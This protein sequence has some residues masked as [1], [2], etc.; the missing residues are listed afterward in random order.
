MQRQ[1]TLL[2]HA[3][4][5]FSGSAGTSKKRL[6][7]LQNQLPSF[8]PLGISLNFGQVAASWIVTQTTPT[9]TDAVCVE[10]HFVQG[11]T[12]MFMKRS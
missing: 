9:C 3:G 7:D 2:S 10:P 1:N 5:P 6:H 4:T 12:S 11:G 8:E